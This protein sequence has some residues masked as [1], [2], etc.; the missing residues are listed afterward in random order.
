MALI[1]T[2]DS[3]LGGAS[4]VIEQAFQIPQGAYQIC[5]DYS[6]VSEEFP[7]FVGSVF[8][9]VFQT[10]LTTSTE[11]R[12]VVFEEVNNA[13]FKPVDDIHFPGGDETTGA[14]PWRK[15][16][17]SPLYKSQGITIATL[18]ITDVG[19][20]I[21]DSVALIDN[22]QIKKV[23]PFLAFPL[24]NKS[25]KIT[26]IFDHI[27]KPY[28]WDDKDTKIMSFTGV[29]AK[30]EYGEDSYWSGAI[31]V[32]GYKQYSKQTISFDN[33]SDDFLYYDGHPGYDYAAT[34]NTGILAAAQGVA[35]F[36]GSSKCPALEIKEIKNGGGYSVKYLHILYQETRD[37]LKKLCDTK[38]KD[39]TD[40]NC[41]KDKTQ[42][43]INE[44]DI[45]ARVGSTCTGSAHL[46]FEVI[47]P[48]KL[49]G[50]RVDPYGW[51]DS[52][53][54]PEDDPFYKENKVLNLRL[55]KE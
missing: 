9:D 46:H 30:P 22:I 44:G 3:A 14:T 38:L 4:S 28:D 7:E 49:G 13:K 32:R 17:C 6:F 33:Y 8:N 31:K 20:T 35:E 11:T 16:I 54:N 40:R 12:T 53:F 37:E 50:I 23:D 48:A 21:F 51:K 36:N 2:G 19:D 47:S 43:K 41:N 29:E 10:T 1:G 25:T 45:I 52:G 5:M 18:T 15:D 24:E 34:A 26:S 42:V 55:W 39:G 27:G